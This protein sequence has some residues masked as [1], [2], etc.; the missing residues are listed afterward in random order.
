MC[1]N[2]VH[3]PPCVTSLQGRGG[4]EQAGCRVSSVLLTLHFVQLNVCT[5]HQS[6]WHSQ[7]KA[8]SWTSRALVGEGEQ[9]GWWTQICSTLIH[10]QIAG[11][12]QTPASQNTERSCTRTHTPLTPT[13]FSHPPQPF[14]AQPFPLTPHRP[15]T[16]GLCPLENGESPL[17]TH[18]ATASTRAEEL[19]ETS[20]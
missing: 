20:E 1:P 16:G 5:V 13:N 3:V 15:S 11:L 8:L 14:P 6:C 4:W 19:P 12:L 9:K 2:A 18:S 17:V 7:G 10:N